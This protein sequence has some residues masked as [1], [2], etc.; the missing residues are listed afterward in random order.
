MGQLLIDADYVEK[1]QARCA[2]CGCPASRTQRLI[3]GENGE[4]RPA[5]YDD[6]IVLV[7]GEDQYQARCR[8]H[9][10]VP[11]RKLQKVSS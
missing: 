2:V 7:A 5:Y 8:H 9:H 6:P 11:K 4:A 1:R 3:I 10:E